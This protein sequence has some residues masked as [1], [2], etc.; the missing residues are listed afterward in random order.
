[1]CIELE[2]IGRRNGS[3]GAGHKFERKLNAVR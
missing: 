3:G 1:M 2:Q